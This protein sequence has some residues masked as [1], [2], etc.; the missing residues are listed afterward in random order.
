MSSHGSRNTFKIEDRTVDAFRDEKGKM[1]KDIN[2]FNPFCTVLSR[3][4]IQRRVQNVITKLAKYEHHSFLSII[5]IHPN[6]SANTQPNRYISN[7]PPAQELATSLLLK[8]AHQRTTRKRKKSHSY[9]K[10]STRP[11]Q[12]HNGNCLARRSYRQIIM[13]MLTRRQSKLSS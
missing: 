6:G 5:T 12:V 9:A 2:R 1:S 3:A 11:Q 7:L 4:P 10:H 13:S 8:P